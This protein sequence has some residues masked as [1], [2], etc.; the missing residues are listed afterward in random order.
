MAGSFGAA[1]VLL[2]A[3]GPLSESMALR[4]TSG[5]LIFALGSVI[6]ITYIISRCA[7]WSCP[8]FIPSQVLHTSG[9]THRHRVAFPP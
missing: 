8:A 4:V 2:L 7:P 1:M 6:I 5:G 3:A 9:G